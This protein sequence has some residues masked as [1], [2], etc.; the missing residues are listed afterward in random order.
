MTHPA[1]L[2]VGEATAARILDGRR[3]RLAYP[4]VIAIR[5]CCWACKGSGWVLASSSPIRFRRCF[6]CYGA[7][8]R[9][10]ERHP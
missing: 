8:G 9:G 4:G 10:E 2:A 6:M 5:Q 7:R 1:P 3:S